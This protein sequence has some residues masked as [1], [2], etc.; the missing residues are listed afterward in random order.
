LTLTVAPNSIPNARTATVVVNGL[1]LR[2][3]Q[4]AAGCSYAVSP[5][6]LDLNADSSGA[7]IALTATPGCGWGATASESWI[8]VLTPS[9][10][11]SATISL[12]ISSNSGDVRHAFLTVAGQRVNVT[13]QT[14]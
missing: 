5:A 8:R 4:T 14:R 12:A 1:A 7:S 11:G 9:G 3:I 6:G 13:Q 2:V 10:M